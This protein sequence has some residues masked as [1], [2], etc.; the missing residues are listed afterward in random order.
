ML[1]D[2]AEFMFDSIVKDPGRSRQVT[3]DCYTLCASLWI[4]NEEFAQ[5]EY[6]RPSIPTGYAYKA[7]SSFW[8]GAKEPVWPLRL[9]DVIA[10]GSGSWQCVVPAANGIIPVVAPIAISEPLGLTISSP[11]VLESRK[12]VATYSGGTLGKFYDALFTFTVAGLTQKA[13]QR[14][15]IKKQ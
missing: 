1:D 2:S 15:Y 6:V 4:A 13:R 14:V 7:L 8:S 12:I 3:L 11:T 5:D 9:N 10:D